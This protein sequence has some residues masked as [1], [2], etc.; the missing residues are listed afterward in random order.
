MCYV[1]GDTLIIITDYLHFKSKPYFPRKH[2]SYAYLGLYSYI[3]INKISYAN[4]SV[5]DY[6][7]AVLTI[8]VKFCYI[9]NTTTTFDSFH[10][11]IITQPKAIAN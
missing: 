5:I 4:V 11:R 9:I 8:V 2:I 3:F 10:V 6:I 1:I 7:S